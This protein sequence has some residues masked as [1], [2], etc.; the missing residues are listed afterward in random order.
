MGPGW[1]PRSAAAVTAAAVGVS[2]APGDTTR[3]WPRF[4]PSRPVSMLTGVLHAL[5]AGAAAAWTAGRAVPL[6]GVLS[7][8]GGAHGDR[9]SPWCTRSS[10]GGC[11]GRPEAAPGSAPPCRRCWTRHLRRVRGVRPGMRPRKRG[12]A[13]AAFTPRIRSNRSRRILPTNRCGSRSPAAQELG[14]RLGVRRW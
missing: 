12:L 6:A 4:G 7:R 2:A 13:W 10:S 11:P 1:W 9:V 5:G 8:S 3:C 14:R